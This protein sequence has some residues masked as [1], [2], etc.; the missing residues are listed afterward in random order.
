[1]D[2]DLVSYIDKKLTVYIGLVNYI[3][4]H[5]KEERGNFLQNLTSYL[6]ELGSIKNAIKAGKCKETK[7]SIN[8]KFPNERDIKFLTGSS[9]AEKQKKIDNFGKIVDGT[10]KNISERKSKEAVLNHFKPMVNYIKQVKLNQLAVFPLLHQTNKQFPSKVL[11][12]NIARGEILFHLKNIVNY[13][14][15]RY[16]FVRAEFK[17]KDQDFSYDSKININTGEFNHTHTFKIEEDRKIHQK[18]GKVMM[19]LSIHKQKQFML[20]KYREVSSVEISLDK[21]LHQ[22][23]ASFEVAFPYKEGT[24]LNVNIEMKVHEAI[25]GNLINLK[26]LT[27]KK[28]F[29]PIDFLNKAPPAPQ[30]EQPT[31]QPISQP[32]PAVSSNIELP[33]SPFKFLIMTEKE[34]AIIE[35]ILKKQKIVNSAFIASYEDKIFG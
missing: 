11:N 32:K 30:R 5:M 16:F 29:P 1:M 31:N 22:T 21:L 12:K 7:Q 20:W 33:K 17:Y 24:F 28:V 15:N 9:L 35:I 10:L 18:I 19:K 25:Q 6:K 2:L 4:K 26:L 8:Q 27:I 3:T 34:R 13:P 23:N 14:E